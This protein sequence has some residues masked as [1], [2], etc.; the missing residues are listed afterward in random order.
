MLLPSLACYFLVLLFVTHSVFCVQV[1]YHYETVSGF[2]CEAFGY[3]PRTGESIK[4]LMRNVEEEGSDRRE[5][6]SD[7]L[8]NRKEKFQKYRLEVQCSV[9]TIQFC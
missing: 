3:I 9:L 4:V 5:G 2:I 1:P 8:E 7:N 6:D